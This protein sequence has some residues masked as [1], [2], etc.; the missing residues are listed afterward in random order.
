L[1]RFVLAILIPS[2]F[3]TRRL[4]LWL[5]EDLVKKD[6]AAV[7]AFIQILALASHCFK[8]R[9]LTRMTVLSDSEWK[10]ITIPTLFLVGENEKIYPARAAVKRLNTV[11]PQIKTEII[12]NAGHDQ[13]LVQTDLVNR[14]ILEFLTSAST[15][16]SLSQTS[17]K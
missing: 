6:R 9:R 5:Y 17:T 8:T 11:A 2:G 12:S 4:I 1:A 10:S 13:L 14:K 3:F 15:A 16:A 7:E